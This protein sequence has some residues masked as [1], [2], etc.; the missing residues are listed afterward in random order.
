MLASKDKKNERIHLTMATN[1]SSGTLTLGTWPDDVVQSGGTIVVN[2]KGGE[3]TLNG[4]N[5]TIITEGNV[6]SVEINGIPGPAATINLDIAGVLGGSLDDNGNNIT[7]SPVSTE[8]YYLQA[9]SLS[10]NGL[11]VGGVAG[12]V[13]FDMPDLGSVI[14]VGQTR[15]TLEYGSLAILQQSSGISF[16]DGLGPD[17]I[18]LPAAEPNPDFA[19]MGVLPTLEIDHLAPLKDV[20]ISQSSLTL[21]FNNGQSTTLT[22]VAFNDPKFFNAGQTA[23]GTLE[24]SETRIDGTP[25]TVIDPSGPPPAPRFTV[26][27]ETSGETMG[28]PG[29]S[30]T[31]PVPGITDDLIMATP[32]NINVGSSLNNVWIAT[33]SGTDAIDLRNSTGNNVIDGGTGSNFL[34]GGSGDDTFFVD[35]RNA[36]STLWSTISGFHAGDAATVW[37]VTPADFNIAWV[38]GQGAAGYTG[39]T[40]DATAPGKPMASLTLVGYGSADLTNGRLTVSFGTDPGSGSPYMSIVGH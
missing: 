4:G 14:S 40:L 22:N 7:I 8:E 20:Q 5:D 27:D 33:G 26:V 2:G 29:A 16:N 32:D 19:A 28:Y 9:V 17:G 1:W 15:G 36:T 24:L 34:T 39:L 12:T 10:G 13:T 18:N 35:D 38:A 11:G 23:S 3:I 25:V 37:G 31:G 6:F 30:Y 21:D